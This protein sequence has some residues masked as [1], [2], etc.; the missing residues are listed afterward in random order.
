MNTITENLKMV[1]S[2]EPN[3]QTHVDILE[4][5][6]YGIDG[7]QQILACGGCGRIHANNRDTEP[8]DS[9]ITG[10]V[11]ELKELL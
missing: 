7:D 8:G 5:I 3:L 11:R 10:Y 4:K 9:P 6:R 1:K 2:L